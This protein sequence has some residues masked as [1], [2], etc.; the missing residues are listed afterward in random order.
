MLYEEA[1]KRINYA[2]LLEQTEEY[3]KEPIN[4]TELGNSI[5]LELLNSREELVEI[6]RRYLNIGRY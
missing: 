4:D 3:R 2:K 1:G 6:A 5:P